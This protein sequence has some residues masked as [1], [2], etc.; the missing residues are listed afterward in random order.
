MVEGQKRAWSPHHVL[1][2]CTQTCI[3]KMAPYLNMCDNIG[4]SAL[5]DG[6]EMVSN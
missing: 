5:S 1:P 4:P 2:T 3:L 6:E